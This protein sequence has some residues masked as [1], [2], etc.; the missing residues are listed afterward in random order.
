[1]KRAGKREEIEKWM[2]KKGIQILAIQETHIDQN[3]RESRAEYT[4]HF[5]GEH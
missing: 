1:M 2:K 3:A 5:S 4:W